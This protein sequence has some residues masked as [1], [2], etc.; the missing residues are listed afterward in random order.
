MPIESE[1]MLDFGQKMTQELGTK[2][3]VVTQ[4]TSLQ[5]VASSPQLKN[6][7]L[8]PKHIRIL[9][10]LVVGIAVVVFI[11]QFINSSMGLFHTVPSGDGQNL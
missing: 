2:S 11:V 4:K 3:F 9:L 7:G 5:T 6:G 10:L 1:L 8:L